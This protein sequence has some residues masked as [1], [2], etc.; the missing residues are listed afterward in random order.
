MGAEDDR[1][2]PYEEGHTDSRAVERLTLFSDAV[3]AIAITLLALD[4]PVPEG[5]TVSGFWS[6]VRDNDGHYG[7]FL[8]SF[9]VIAAAWSTHHDMF[10][11]LRR[12]TSRLRTINMVWLLTIVLNPFATRMLTAVGNPTLEVHAFRFGFYALLEILESA[13]FLALRPGQQPRRTAGLRRRDRG[14]R[15]DQSLHR[16]PSESRSRVIAGYLGGSCSGVSAV[17]P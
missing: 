6:S 1:L 13:A 5:D 2:M 3:V 17:D 12:P 11:Y 15:R 10:R 16:R 14:R 9:A 4:L 8:L 7:A